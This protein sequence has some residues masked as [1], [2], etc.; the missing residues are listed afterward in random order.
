MKE[1]M[2]EWL[3]FNNVKYSVEKNPQANIK[4]SKQLYE[5]AQGPSI[6]ANPQT[7][8]SDTQITAPIAK[9]PVSGSDT[10]ITAPIAQSPAT[11]SDTHI[12]AP[13]AQSPVS[14]GDTQITPPITQS[15]AT[16]SDTRYR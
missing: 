2:E 16:G 5:L 3:Y 15:P 4:L 1:S 14:G 10:Q 8:G 9:S 7:A 11:G 13:I 6:S 12:T